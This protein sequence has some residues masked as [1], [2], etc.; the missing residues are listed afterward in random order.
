MDQFLFCTA[1]L[2]TSVGTPSPTLTPIPTGNP[3]LCQIYCAKCDDVKQGVKQDV[4][5][6]VGA[7]PFL[8]LGIKA[9]YVAA[10][11]QDGRNIT[12]QYLKDV[13]QA[14]IQC[15]SRVPTAE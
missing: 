12:L 7:C 10:A 14:P 11:K 15:Q 2:L 4:K 1:L 9:S 8:A 3:Q 5:Q 13:A 6:P